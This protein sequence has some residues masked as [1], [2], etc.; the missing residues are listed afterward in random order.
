MQQISQN[1][2]LMESIVNTPYMQ[3]VTQTLASNPELTRQI[4]ENNPLL[5]NNPEM[6]E[7]LMRSMPNLLQQLQNP[8][9]QQLLTNPE[10]LQAVLQIQEGMQRLQQVAPGLLTG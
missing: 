3:A 8:D 4:M 10:A 2:N 5:Q 6:R 7:T 9:M 1:P